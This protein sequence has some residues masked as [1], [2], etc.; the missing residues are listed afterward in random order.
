MKRYNIEFITN[1]KGTTAFYRN[2]DN[3]DICM[4]DEI[5]LELKKAKIFDELLKLS[6]QNSLFTNWL[7]DKII[8]I[9]NK[10]IN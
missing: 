9:E 10:I 7:N 1:E 3:G 8:D 2:N 5:E 6:E 4:Y